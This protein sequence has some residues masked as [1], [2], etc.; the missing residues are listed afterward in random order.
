[1]IVTID[2]PAGSGKSTTARAVA[3]RLGLRY[4]DS[5]AFYRAL[6][7]AALRAGLAPEAWDQLGDERLNAFDVRG[8]P[9]AS[10]Y[11]MTVAGDDVS[12]DIRAPEVNAHVSR[13]AR[14]PAVRAWLHERLRSV[15]G[16]TDLVAD[17]RDMGTV[18]FPE[19]DV[20][21]FLTADLETRARRRLG[22]H[23]G[24]PAQMDALR[25]ETERLAR[26]DRID[27][28]RAVAPLRPAADAIHIDTSGLSFDE[29]VDRI[30]R[31]VN[32]RRAPTPPPTP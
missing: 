3:Q 12:A 2:G 27:T 16:G 9:A 13:M 19:A 7:L 17:G 24:D 31:I 6:T 11:R 5:G 10:G 21:V 14:L 25:E 23:G 18:V 30:V 15:A 22:E 8:V 4:L 26:R 20:K 32:A 28:E 29:Q 1:V